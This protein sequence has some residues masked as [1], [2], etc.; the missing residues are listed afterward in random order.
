LHLKETEK[1]R[2]W[3]AGLRRLFNLYQN[4]HVLSLIARQNLTRFNK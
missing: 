4:N 3:S 1:T 2:S